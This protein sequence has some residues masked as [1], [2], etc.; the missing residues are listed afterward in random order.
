MKIHSNKPQVVLE[1]YYRL[2][3]GWSLEVTENTQEFD[4]SART[5]YRY[6]HLLRKFF[7]DHQEGELIK[8]RKTKRY[9]LA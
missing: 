4:I 5:F 9:R 8:D 3:K 6:V 7:E 2:K 1:M